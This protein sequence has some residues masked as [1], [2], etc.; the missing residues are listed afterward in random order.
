LDTKLFDLSLENV[1]SSEPILH[2]VILQGRLEKE[3]L[4]GKY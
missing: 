1:Y 4:S 3:L 2:W